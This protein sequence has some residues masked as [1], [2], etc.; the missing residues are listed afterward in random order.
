LGFDLD[1][2]VGNFTFRELHNSLLTHS[3]EMPSN[4]RGYHAPEKIDLLTIFKFYAR[5]FNQGVQWEDDMDTYFKI[6]PTLMSY[7]IIEKVPTTNKSDTIGMEMLQ[8]SKV[9]YEF[10]EMLQ[11]WRIYNNETFDENDSQIPIIKI[12]KTK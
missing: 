6:G 4:L 5:I 9:G 12:N 11:K 2:K 1:Q 7:G 10:L 8:T 3:I